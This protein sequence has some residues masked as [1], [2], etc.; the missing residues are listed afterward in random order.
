LGEEI[1]DGREGGKEV[2]ARRRIKDEKDAKQRFDFFHGDGP[3]RSD[4]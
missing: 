3:G 2:K 1:S 4:R